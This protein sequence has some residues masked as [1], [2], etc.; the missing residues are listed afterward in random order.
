MRLPPPAP[1]DILSDRPAAAGRWLAVGAAAA[2][3]LLR[4][5]V[6]GVSVETA[7]SVHEALEALETKRRQ[8]VH[9][10]L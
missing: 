7:D 10:C 8:R 5:P 2:L 1:D 9:E 4:R 3:G 6:P